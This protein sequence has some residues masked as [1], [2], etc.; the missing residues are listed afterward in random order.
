M[1]VARGDLAGTTRGAD[2]RRGARLADRARVAV[3]IDEPVPEV[4]GRC[5][6]CHQTLTV[7]INGNLCAA[8]GLYVC[9]FRWRVDNKGQ[10]SHELPEVE[11]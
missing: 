4:L 9:V 11:R 3:R 6:H 5:I 10:R 8:D 7:G 1:V 2:L